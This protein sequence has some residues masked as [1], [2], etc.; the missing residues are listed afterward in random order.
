MQTDQFY[1]FFYSFFDAEKLVSDFADVLKSHGIEIV[2]NSEL[3]RLCLN[4]IDVLE[5]HLKPQ[6]RDPK[7]DIRIQ[8]REYTGM[9]DLMVK[10]VKAKDNPH[11]QQLIPHLQKLNIANPLQNTQTSIRNQE[12]NKIFELFIATLCLGLNTEEILVDN[13]NQSKGD[14]P[15]VIATIGEKMWGFGCKSLHSSHPQTIFENIEKAV[16]QIEKAPAQVGIPVLNIK[17]LVDHDK[18]WPIVEDGEE[19]EFGAFLDINI[20]TSMMYS[21]IQQIHQELVN[22]VGEENLKEVF[23]NKKAQPGCL[24]YCPT[25]TSLVINF[26]PVIT[27][28]NIFNLMDFDNVSKEC[29]VVN[30]KLNHQLQLTK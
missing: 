27:R 12:N 6:L 17:N 21:F 7:A 25:T 15:D 20:P 22:H 26:R 2:C 19:P 3:E 29:M 16:D 23:K 13:P 24:V 11:F 9:Q 10:I 30:M 1:S 28:L 4:I 18:F 14:N 8:F 5:K